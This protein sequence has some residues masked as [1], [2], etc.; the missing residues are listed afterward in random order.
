MSAE[1]ILLVYDAQCPVCD[2]YC[3]AI[4]RQGSLPG[5]RLIDARGD[6]TVLEEVTRR[7]LDIDQGMV[8][9]VGGQLYYGADAI[10]VLTIHG[11]S[12]GVMARANQWLFGSARRSRLLYPALRAARNLLLKALRR[13]HI[14]NLR[15]PGRDRF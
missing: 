4:D 8:V 9:K 7:G 6:S 13:T 5:L 14:N 10:H 3:R 15:V 2:A 12:S 11:R 1:E